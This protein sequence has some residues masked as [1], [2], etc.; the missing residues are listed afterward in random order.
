MLRTVCGIAGFMV[1]LVRV[2]CAS[3][4]IPLVPVSGKVTLDGKPLP[5]KL[6]QFVPL[7]GTPGVGGARNTDANGAYTILAIRPGSLSDEEGIPAGDYKVVITEPQ[8]LIETPLPEADSEGN[9]APAIA[10]PEDFQ[11]RRHRSGIPRKYTS[12]ETTDLRATVPPEGGIFDF[13]LH[14]R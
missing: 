12:Q 10:S 2:G 3:D 6:V 14:S 9:P 4:E 1:C 13:D 7:P 5:H 8:I 11:K